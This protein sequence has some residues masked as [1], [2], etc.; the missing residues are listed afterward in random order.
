MATAAFEVVVIG[1]A[2]EQGRY[3]NAAGKDDLVLA[4]AHPRLVQLQN[5]RDVHFHRQGS[6]ALAE[7]VVAAIL[8]V[9]HGVPDGEGTVAP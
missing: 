1:A 5:P 4:F 3:A 6:E 2:V 8:A 9:A 7:R